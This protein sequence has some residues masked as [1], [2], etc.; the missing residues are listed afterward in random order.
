MGRKGNIRYEK[1]GDDRKDNG[2]RTKF[3]DCENNVRIK[4]KLNN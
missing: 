1:W 3:T 2:G 4:M